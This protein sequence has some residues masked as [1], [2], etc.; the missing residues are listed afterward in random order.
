[1]F[2]RKKWGLA[3]GGGFLRG[4]AHIGVLKVL[5]GEGL[6]PDLVAGTSAG[7]I[8]AALFCAGWSPGQ[9]E[10]L[11]LRL[12][13]AV[14][15]DPCSTV[16]NLG[17]MIAKIVFD[18]LRLPL[19]PRAPLGLV[20]GKRMEHWLEDTFQRTAFRDLKTF[21]AIVAVDINT[22]T[23]VVFTDQDA[24]FPAPPEDIVFIRGV[25]VAPAVVASCAVPGVFQPKRIGIRLLVDGGLKENVPVET[26]SLLGADVVVGVDVG[27]DGEPYKDIRNIVQLLSQSLEIIG[28]EVT[29]D[30]LARFAHL[31]V[32]PVLK[33]VAPWDFGKIPYCIRQGEAAARQAVP[34]L[35]KLLG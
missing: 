16:V 35:K 34:A 24:Y 14:F 12:R 15:Y 1:M 13:P 10:E 6:R 28:S 22:G 3:L 29:R 32:Q 11:A 21:L 5:A 26:L 17:A 7:S 8:V 18:F 2:R 33:D 4:A 23:R 9:I 30:K 31:L 27:Y 19:L 25:P 20:S